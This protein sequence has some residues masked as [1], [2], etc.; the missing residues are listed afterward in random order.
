MVG[1]N[2]INLPL[3]PSGT[4]LFWPQTTLTCLMVVEAWHREW[5]GKS[6][7]AMAQIGDASHGLWV[8][9]KEVFKFLE[10][11]WRGKQKILYKDR[12]HFK[13]ITCIF[14]RIEFQLT[15]FLLDIQAY[16]EAFIHELNNLYKIC[17]FELSR[18]E[19][20]STWKT[21]HSIIKLITHSSYQGSMRCRCF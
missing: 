14:W 17:F 21:T 11:S 7:N 4:S 9:N 13:L 1:T 15:G 6:F 5:S 3:L 10:L 18:S 16:L 2:H 20:R 8:L 12:S 19:S